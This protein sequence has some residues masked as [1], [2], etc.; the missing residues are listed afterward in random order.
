MLLDPNTL[1]PDGTVA[2]SGAAFSYDG[3]RL[4]YS[5]SRV[6]LG[7]AGVARPRRRHGDRS[8][9][10]GALVEVLGRVVE[11]R[12]QRLLLQPLRRARV[13]QPVQGHQLLP[14][15]VLPPARH[16]SVDRPARLRAARSQGVELR[17]DHLRRRALSDHRRE[18][19]HGAGER[20]LRQGPEHRRS[21]D[22]AAARRGRALRLSRQRRDDVLLSDHQG[23]AARAHRRDRPARPR[24]ARDRRANR[25]PARRR[26]VL[27]RPHRRGI[28][29]RRARARRRLRARRSVPRRGCAARTRQRRGLQRQARRHRD[30]L[31]LHQLHRAGL[32]LPLRRAVEPVDARLHAAD[33]HD[34][35]RSRARRCSTRPRTARASR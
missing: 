15:S 4:A 5:I 20:G 23:R 6:G 19:R 24:A 16:A 7:L 10:P 21:G 17:R 14:Q 2:L 35:R 18:P 26:D 30:V 22:R 12:R 31:Q 8:A 1:S 25:R 32:D 9:G 13:R 33:S 29:A 27:R 11:A 28:F 34:A 3:S